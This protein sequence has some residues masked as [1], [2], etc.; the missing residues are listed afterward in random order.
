M[1]R[2]CDVEPSL[3]KARWDGVIT[4]GFCK[5]IFPRRTARILDAI[6]P[7]SFKTEIGRMSLTS[8][9]I[10][11]S[12]FFLGIIEM[13]AF[14]QEYGVWPLVTA[15]L[16]SSVSSDRNGVGASAESSTSQR[17]TSQ[18]IPSNPTAFFSSFANATP[19]SSPFSNI[20]ESH[21][22]ALIDFA[23]RL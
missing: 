20:R 12:S 18:F 23:L 22:S 16:I 5:R 7:N 1:L 14:L 17:T 3:R 4:S 11:P 10:E 15:T 2:H 21:N 19:L 6:F 9:D 13:I 8:L